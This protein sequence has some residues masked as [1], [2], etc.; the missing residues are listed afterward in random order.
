M[1]KEG[2]KGG[3]QKHIEAPRSP[4]STAARQNLRE[5]F[6]RKEFCH[7]CI[8]SLTPQPAKHCR[9]AEPAGNALAVAVQEDPNQEE[10]LPEE[11]EQETKDTSHGNH[12]ADI[13]LYQLNLQFKHVIS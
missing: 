4:R 11:F 5:I 12:S 9:Q 8:R 1:W 7:F 10:D 3:G 13:P 6:D 2:K